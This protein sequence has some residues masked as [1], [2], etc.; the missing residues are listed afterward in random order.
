[1][2]QPLLLHADV[3]P[4]APPASLASRTPLAPESIERSVM[5]IRLV[6]LRLV[7]KL[8]RQVSIDDL[9]SAGFLGLLDANQR[10]EPERGQRFDAYVEMRVRG[11]MLDALRAADPLSRGLR[12]RTR[13]RERAL[14][15][16][17]GRLGRPP[18]DEEMATELGLSLDD[19]HAL[20]L[21]AARGQNPSNLQATSEVDDLATLPDET[22]VPVDERIDAERQRR[23]ARRAVE[24]LPPRLRLVIDLYYRGELTLRAIGQRLG[25]T[26]A[27]V[28]QL[29]GQ[30]IAK[31]RADVNSRRGD[32]HRRSERARSAEEEQGPDSFGPESFG[33]A[34]AAA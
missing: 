5:M 12:D 26:E 34:S 24:R 30:A 14:R 23:A 20:T 27:R 7:R 10:A 21:Y 3:T 15:T 1:M 11:A 29:H 25:V 33:P 9:I 22:H 31:L 8:P 16:L 32:R 4:I 17:E 28:C 2:A 6:A 18:R 13:Q 19:Y